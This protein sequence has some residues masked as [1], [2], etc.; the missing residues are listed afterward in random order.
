MSDEQSLSANEY[1]EQRLA[2]MRKLEELGFKA[3]GQAFQR[4][5]L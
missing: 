1:R 4:T 5:R 2:N 3:F